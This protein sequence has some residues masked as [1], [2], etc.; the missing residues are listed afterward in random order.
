MSHPTP[1]RLRRVL[2]FALLALV[3]LSD[4]ALA[5]TATEVVARCIVKAADVFVG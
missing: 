5:Q 2:P 4:P 3:T 1:G